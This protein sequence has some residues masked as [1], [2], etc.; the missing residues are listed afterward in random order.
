[1]IA[2]YVYI[3]LHK[4]NLKLLQS[5]ICHTGKCYVRCPPT[6]SHS[7]NQTVHILL[8][9][10]V[11]CQCS[12]RTMWFIILHTGSCCQFNS[13]VTQ[14]IRHKADK[15]GDAVTGIWR[16]AIRT[17]HCILCQ[18]QAL[19]GLSNTACGTIK[20]KGTPNRTEGPEGSLRYSSTLS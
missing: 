20:C 9:L 3:Y 5:E 17:C 7:K 15:G 16:Q 13:H 10:L 14:S 4:F 12:N 19:F 2:L 8:N 18:N 11:F 1:L 6:L